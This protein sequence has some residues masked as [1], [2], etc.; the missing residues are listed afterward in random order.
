MTRMVLRS[1]WPRSKLGRPVND[2][3]EE[4]KEGW[5]AKNCV[6]EPKDLILIQFCEAL[7]NKPLWV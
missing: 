2:C 6:W 4:R 1:N 3:R 7:G 5:E